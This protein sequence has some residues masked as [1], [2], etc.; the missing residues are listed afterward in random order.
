MNDRNYIIFNDFNTL[1]YFLIEEL[2]TVP[3]AEEKKELIRIDGRSGYLT[4]TNNGALESITYDVELNLKTKEDIER[5]KTAFRGSGKLIISNDPTKFYYATVINKIEFERQVRQRRKCIISFELQPYG[6]ELDNKPMTFVEQFELYNHTNTTA[7]PIITINGKGN[8]TL[9]V[10]GT[11]FQIKEVVSSIV[12]D[13]QLEEAYDKETRFSKNT[14]VLGDYDHLK[15]GY[16][17]IGWFGD[18]TS[19]EIIPNW[20][21]R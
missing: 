9:V 18:V 20:R 12:L 11:I 15:E 16:N 3:S 1:P 14:D 10:N 13:F 2:P 7:Q 4:N 5:I 6:Y 21:W 8:I 17:Q 19:I